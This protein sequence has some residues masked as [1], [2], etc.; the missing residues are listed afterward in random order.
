MLPHR[1]DR[2]HAA[3]CSSTTTPKTKCCG[4][5]AWHLGHCTTLSFNGTLKSSRRPQR[6]TNAKVKPKQRIDCI[7][8]LSFSIM[9]FPWK[10]TSQ[11]ASKSP[12]AKSQKPSEAKAK[13]GS[14]KPIDTNFKKCPK[15]QLFTDRQ[16]LLRRWS[17]LCVYTTYLAYIGRI[18]SLQVC[19]FGLK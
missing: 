9:V 17:C 12:I 7:Y 4:S 15:K 16:E 19:K 14:Q 6:P 18:V 11:K 8:N 2:C 5:H 3:H 10:P 13:T 1:E